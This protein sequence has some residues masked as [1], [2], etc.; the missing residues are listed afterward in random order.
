MYTFTCKQHITR[1]GILTFSP[2]LT[3][4]TYIPALTLPDK[5]F[6]STAASILTPIVLGSAVGIGISSKCPSRCLQLFLTLL[7]RFFRQED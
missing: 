6:A 4:T 1:E 2:P 5:I 3:M 7:T